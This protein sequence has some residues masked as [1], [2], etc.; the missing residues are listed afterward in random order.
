MSFS[1]PFHCS[2]SILSVSIAIFVSQLIS[3]LRFSL[4]H[5]LCIYLL[6]LYASRAGCA[7]VYLFVRVFLFLSVCVLVCPPLCFTFWCSAS[8]TVYLFI[9]I[10]LFFFWFLFQLNLPVPHI[11]SLERHLYRK[12]VAWSPGAAGLMLSHVALMWLSNLWR[13]WQSK[14]IGCIGRWQGA[15]SWNLSQWF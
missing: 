8:S 1:S 3:P 4:Y 7:A 5:F 9:F 13:S 12:C 14:Y 6:Y 2:W 10:Y 11:S 15:G